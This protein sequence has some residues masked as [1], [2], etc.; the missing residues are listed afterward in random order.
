MEDYISITEMCKR[1][2]YARQTVYNKISKKEFVLNI[3]YIKPNKKKVLF[4]WS[5]LEK[6]L[7]GEHFTKPN[8]QLTNKKEEIDPCQKSQPKSQIP[9]AINI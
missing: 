1:T 5:A 9:S 8:N 4:I 2:N 6:W 7:R 3:H